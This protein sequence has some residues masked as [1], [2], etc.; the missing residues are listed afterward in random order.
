MGA[1]SSWHIGEKCR[2]LTY[3]EL[4][5]NIHVLRPPVNPDSNYLAGSLTSCC[6]SKRGS[7]A[8]L[9]HSAGLAYVSIARVLVSSLPVL[10]PGQTM[11]D[12]FMCHDN[13]YRQGT[14]SPQNHNVG[15]SYV[16]LLFPLSS[17]LSS[18]FY[19][20]VFLLPPN[21]AAYCRTNTAR[22]MQGPVR[23]AANCAP[24]RLGS[25]SA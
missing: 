22:E 25:G 11:T 21:I 10:V 12:S 1:L 6:T 8:Q 7:P 24:H 3:R 17:V 16:C 19:Y 23:T 9:L 13:T 2:M 15:A 14:L 4:E 20:L 18:L 5:T